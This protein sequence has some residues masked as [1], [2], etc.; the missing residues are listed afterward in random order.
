MVRGNWSRSGEIP[1]R[2]GEH[3]NSTPHRKDLPLPGIEPRTL[4][5]LASWP[6]FEPRTFLLWGNLPLSHCAPCGS[7]LSKPWAFTN[8][9]KILSLIYLFPIGTMGPRDW[10]SNKDLCTPVVSMQNDFQEYYWL[11]PFHFHC[12]SPW[13]TAVNGCIGSGP[14]RTHT[15]QVTNTHW[16]AHTCTQHGSLACS[17][18]VWPRDAPIL[19]QP[20]VPSTRWH[21]SCAAPAPSASNHHDLID[22]LI[23][24]WWPTLFFLL[25]L[26]YNSTSVLLLA[27]MWHWSSG[28]LKVNLNIHET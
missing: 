5:M 6:G 23:D 10:H 2:R 11:P 3:A 15:G 26:S 27:A 14:A 8:K 20:A 16:W 22:I 19:Q 7:I 1:H 9:A 25:K 4:L 28:A 18:C 17:L 13:A 24:V 21:I 12:Y